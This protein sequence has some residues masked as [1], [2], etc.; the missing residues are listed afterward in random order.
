MHAQRITSH[1]QGAA[2]IRRWTL[3][4]LP[5][6]QSLVAYD[7]FLAIGNESQ[8]GRPIPLARLCAALP[9]DAA[10]IASQ[11][12]R[13][14]QAGLIATDPDGAAA[15]GLSKQAMVLPTS[16]FEVL[17]TELTRTVD[18]VYILRKGLRDTQLAVDGSI[19][20]WREAIETVYDNF[21]DLGWLYLH[22]FGSVCFLMA[23]LAQRAFESRGHRARCESGFVE[24]LHEGR[25]AYVLGGQG[26]AQP[27]QIEG[28]ACCVVD[29][30]VVVDF[31]LGN[32]RKGYRRDFPWAVAAPLR[33]DGATL[34]CAELPTG[35]AVCWRTS[36]RSPESEREF[37]KLRPVADELMKRY[38][39]T[40]GD[41]AE[42]GGI[43]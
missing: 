27:G 13:W 31:G 12:Q 7:L 11:I 32:V 5:S 15:G 28:H 26:Y 9:F 21:Y 22:N 17:L 25:L 36:W 34:A 14:V 33:A 41:P 24:I 10:D 18:S 42:A 43:A 19:E 23:Q 16:R 20:P 29:D 8:A 1:L 3:D 4:H 30:A 38:R 40:F 2:A 39:L 35:Y 37:A 6:A